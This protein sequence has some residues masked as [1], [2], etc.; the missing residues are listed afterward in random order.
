MEKNS[1]TS[2]F[3]HKETN[4]ESTTIFWTRP[5]TLRSVPIDTCPLQ[6]PAGCLRYC[7]VATDFHG[8]D[9]DHDFHGLKCCRFQ[10][11][12]IIRDSNGRIGGQKAVLDNT[13]EPQRNR[14][15]RRNKKNAEEQMEATGQKKR[16]YT[17]ERDKTRVGQKE[18]CQRTQITGP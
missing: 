5:L 7:S 3:M 12:K 16:R 11:P 10:E 14:W 13:K 8:H 18:E 2:Q 6:A 9:N 15:K 4:C 1:P 17:D